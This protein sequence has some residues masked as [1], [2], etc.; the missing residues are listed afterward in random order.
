MNG[1]EELSDLVDTLIF[2]ARAVRLDRMGRQQQPV[3]FP[4]PHAGR[5]GPTSARFAFFFSTTGE[6]QRFVIC[7]F[8][9]GSELVYLIVT[10]LLPCPLL[11]ISGD[12][13]VLIRV[14]FNG[15]MLI[16]VSDFF[17]S[18]RVT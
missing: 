12:V 18:L 6:K 3:F 5:K 15:N 13:E 8:A 7:K 11:Y 9:S 2:S 1:T 17:W 16:F 10:L 14:D 4:Y